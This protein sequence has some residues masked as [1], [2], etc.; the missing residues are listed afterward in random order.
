MIQKVIIIIIFLFM[1]SHKRSLKLAPLRHMPTVSYLKPKTKKKNLYADKTFKKNRSYYLCKRKRFKKDLRK[2]SKEN[3][4]FRQVNFHNDSWRHNGCFV[5]ICFHW[6]NW[7]EV[8][9]LMSAVTCCS[10]L[11][12]LSF[13]L[14]NNEDKFVF[15][16]PS[17]FFHFL[18]MIF[19]QIVQHI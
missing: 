15:I 18:C 19:N 3:V 4:E 7:R 12:L 9:M 10:W 16:F 13:S 5:R 14:I 11:S 6:G 1:F 8:L 2:I 17:S